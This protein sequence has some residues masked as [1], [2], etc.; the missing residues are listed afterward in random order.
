MHEMGKI[1]D[2]TGTT[3]NQVESKHSLSC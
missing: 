3:S 1:V 2:Y